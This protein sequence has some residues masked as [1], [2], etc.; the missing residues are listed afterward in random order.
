VFAQP[1]QNIA[2]REDVCKPTELQGAMPFKES[3]KL[4]L[5]FPSVLQRGPTVA[6]NSCKKR[7]R[8]S[9]F[10]FD[11]EDGKEDELAGSESKRPRASWQPAKTLA[12]RV[13]GGSNALP[14][15]IGQEAADNVRSR[16]TDEQPYLPRL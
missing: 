6:P 15:D 13:G 11:D 10:D 12:M 7:R 14:G 8:S 16:S 3:S 2:Q 9:I 4:K 5:R 1:V